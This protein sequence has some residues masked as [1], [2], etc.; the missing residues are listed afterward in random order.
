M[1]FFNTAGPVNF[2]DHYCLPPLGRFNL[3]E[4][5]RLIGQKKYFV[6]HA[7]RQTGKTS[8]LLELMEHLNA[9]EQYNCLYIN[10]EGAQ[11]ARENVYRGI[12]AILSEIAEEAEYYL[13]DD[14]LQDICPEMLEKK[15]EDAALKAALSRWSI[16]SDKHTIL[17]IDE[18]D[19]LVGDTLISVLR[20]LR[21][22][23]VKRP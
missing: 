21:A 2:D 13:H 14:S 12:R 6:L 1:K 17:L 5:L 20:Q 4:I 22:G 7:P 10:V 18:I 11:G 9:G 8:C 16:K 15:G 23:Y 3:D 19:S